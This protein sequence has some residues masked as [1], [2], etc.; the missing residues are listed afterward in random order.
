MPAGSRPGERRGG[1][2]KGSKNKTTDERLAELAKTGE[3]PL[4]YMLRVMRDTKLDQHRRDDMAKAASAYCHP[5]L[6]T[7]DHGNKDGTA[8]VVKILD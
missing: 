6:A 7:I 8:L 2:K 5:R 3:M 4:D 1:R